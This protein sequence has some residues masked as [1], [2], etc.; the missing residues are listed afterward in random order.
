MKFISAAFG[1]ILYQFQMDEIRPPSGFDYLTT[2][3]TISERYR[4]LEP[5]TDSKEIID[6][7]IIFGKGAITLCNTSIQVTS[8][9][10]YNDGILLNTLN[11][12]DADFLID[13][14]IQWATKEFGLREPITPPRRNYS[15]QVVVDFDASID[16]LLK[17][18]SSIVN[19]LNEGLRKCSNNEF[20]LHVARLGVSG[21]PHVLRFPAQSA[22][23]IEPRGGLAYS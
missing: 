2:I 17:G 22:F 3:R 1:Q 8:L 5:P 12:N 19:V 14:F 10:I 11:T 9:G 18:F 13:D 20:D 7:G 4:F 6:K 21:D 16:G 15:S 23:Y